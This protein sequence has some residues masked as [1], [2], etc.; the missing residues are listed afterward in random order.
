M[1]SPAGEPP[2]QTP[3]YNAAP[4]P[5]VTKSTG[6]AVDIRV[7]RQLAK[8]LKPA[9]RADVLPPT[10]DDGTVAENCLPI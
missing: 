9:R 8:P 10:G 3:G 2:L 5:G 4:P 6:T 7:G 1:R